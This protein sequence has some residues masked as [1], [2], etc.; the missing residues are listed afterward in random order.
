VAHPNVGPF[1][2]RQL[3]QRLVTSNPSPDYISRVSA[4]FDDNGS[5]VRGDLGAVFR[6]ILLD[7]E[8]R[9]TS[10]IDDP[11]FGKVREPIVRWVQLG[12]AFHATSDSGQF[13]HFGG[14]AIEGEADH[15]ELVPFGQYPY[16]A[17]SVFNFFLPTYQPNGPAGNAGLVAPEMEIVHSYTAI[18]TTNLF[19]R[20]IVEEFYITD[21]EEADVWLDLQGEV[22]LAES[23]PVALIDRLDLLLTYGTLSAA[24]RQI[25]LDAILPLDDALQQVFLALY[26]VTISPEYAVQR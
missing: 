1:L 6:A 12:R 21:T 5:G 23:D 2:G 8:A 18:A 7:P 22:D 13:R 20:A 16:F 19:N 9:D 17:P 25:V 4:A 15:G 26:L 3:I 24:T 10:R 11:T 14:G